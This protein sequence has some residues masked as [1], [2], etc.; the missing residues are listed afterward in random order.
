MTQLHQRD[1]KTDKRTDSRKKQLQ[2]V[3]WESVA[4]NALFVSVDLIG[5]KN[6]VILENYNNVLVRMG[7]NVLITEITT[8]CNATTNWV[9]T[10]L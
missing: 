10:Y 4:N 7:N 6:Q 1:Q 5:G 2:P 3:E 9:A 8:L